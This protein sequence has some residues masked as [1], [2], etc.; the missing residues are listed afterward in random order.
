MVSDL[1]YVKTIVDW[2]ESR[3]DLFDGRIY[4]DG[5]SQNG[6]FASFIDFCLS[7]KITG[8]WG[9]WGG[10]QCKKDAEEKE[11]DKPRPCF[12]EKG[13]VI[14]CKGGYLNNYLWNHEKII[15]GYECAIAEG[16]SP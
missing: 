7:E 12:S 11:W 1:G 6:G 15:D 4:I 10:D 2:I 8:T 9:G 5:F 16:H 14:A 13:P 3:P